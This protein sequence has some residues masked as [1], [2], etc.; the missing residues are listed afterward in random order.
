VKSRH[1]LAI[2][3]NDNA[4]LE[5]M[6]CALAFEL[7]MIDKNNFLSHWTEDKLH[8]FRRTTVAAILNTDMKVHFDLASR[9][10]EIKSPEEVDPNNAEQRR[11]LLSV[12]VHAADLGNPVLPTA[13]CQAWAFRVVS[14]FHRQYERE[15]AEGL[16]FAPFMACRPQ[17]T[18]EVAKL[19]ISFINYVVA[20]MWT[21]MA[22][23]LPQLRPRIDQL[24]EN[25]EHW[26]TL[27]D[28]Q[29]DVSHNSS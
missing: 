14:E 22:S 2:T 25:L 16:P 11:F 8:I 4:V 20:P 13:Q 29:L 12:F 19:Q 10:Q 27:R 21:A 9:L 23:V 6:H 3:Y 24:Q 26:Q 18:R 7:L 5:N 28:Q 15:K 1:K 17:D